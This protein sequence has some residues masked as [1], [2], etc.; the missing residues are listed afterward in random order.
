MTTRCID[1]KYSVT[2]REQRRQFARL[3]RRG[4]TVEEAK[5]ATPRCQV[6]TTRY[7]RNRKTNDK[8]EGPEGGS[9]YNPYKHKRGSHTAYS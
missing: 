1:C 6:C 3:L 2:W 5:A 4:F 8:P 9:G 7:M